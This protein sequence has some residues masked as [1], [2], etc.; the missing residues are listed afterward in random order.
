M[1]TVLHDEPEQ[2]KELEEG[3]VPDAQ[4]LCL[5]AVGELAANVA[6]FSP[7]ANILTLAAYEQAQ[8]A[9]RGECELAIVRCTIASSRPHHS[10]QK[11]KRT[12]NRKG[13]LFFFWS[14]WRVSEGKT[15]NNCFTRRARAGQGVSEAT[16]VA[17]DRT[18]LASRRRTRG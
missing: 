11:E 6:E 13:Y 12:D 15:V 10:N 3:I 7:T 4:R 17:R 2:G 1:I 14:K 5:R 8:R 18:M 9:L 16:N